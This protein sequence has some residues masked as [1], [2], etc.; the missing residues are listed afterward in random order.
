MFELSFLYYDRSLSVKV[1]PKVQTDLAKTHYVRVAR[2]TLA[3]IGFDPQKKKQS[4]SAALWNSCNMES[5]GLG[6]QL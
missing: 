5:A 1:A 2:V 6:I 3:A 4:S